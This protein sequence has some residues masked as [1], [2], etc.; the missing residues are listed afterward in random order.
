MDP[1]TRVAELS[2]AQR[3]MVEIAKALSKQPSIFILDE[4]TAS[5]TDKETK[6]LFKILRSLK[7][8]GV[9]IIYISHRLE[10]VFELADRITVLKDGKYQGTFPSNKLTKDE[11][12]NKMIG[13]ELKTLQRSRPISDEILLAVKNISGSRFTNVSFELHRGEIVGLAGLVGAGRSEIAR[14]I[15]GIDKIHSGKIIFHDRPFHANHPSVAIRAG[16]VYVTEDRKNEGL[17]Q[18][19]SVGDNIIAASLSRVMSSGF[20]DKSTAVRLA[21]EARDRLRISAS[22]ISQR[23]VNLSGGNQQK[24]MLAKW[25]LTHPEVLII[26]EPT[27][28]IDIGAKYEI[29]G[30]LKTMAAE[31]KA[32]LM[33]SSELSELI[34]LCDRIVVINAGSVA[35]E[36]GE[37]NM[38]E[39]KVMRLAT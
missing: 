28:G 33:I 6:T 1:R 32:I 39:E 23:V 31:G 5:L 38:T 21:T 34:G 11:L 13:R 27:H 4:P 3:Q 26:D 25:L 19:M 37:G 18:E 9:S 8:K 29:Y 22:D 30:I 36:L 20:Y 7:S 2:P 14:A 12:I 15:S 17:F 24:V 35:G 16:L 10:E